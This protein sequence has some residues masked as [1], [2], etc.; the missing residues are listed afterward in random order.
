MFT[1]FTNCSSN[2]K[3]R[4]EKKKIGKKW[5]KVHWF[6]HIIK[7]SNIPVILDPEGEERIGQKKYLKK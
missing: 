1:G 2:L 3:M 7:R 5:I 6:G 4:E